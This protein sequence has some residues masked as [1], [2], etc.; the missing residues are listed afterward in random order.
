MSAS[1]RKAKLVSLS[2]AAWSRLA[3]SLIVCVLVLAALATVRPRLEGTS[4]E[5]SD[6]RAVQVLPF[7]HSSAAQRATI[8]RHSQR[9]PQLDTPFV[10]DGSSARAAKAV[11]RSV[12]AA[13]RGAR[14]PAVRVRGYDATAPPVS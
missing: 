8:E 4:R 9:K 1:T 14:F 3:G 6:A 13:P 10:S 11:A 7:L 5:W 2:T 12:P